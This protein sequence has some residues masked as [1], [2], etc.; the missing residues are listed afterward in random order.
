MAESIAH[1]KHDHVAAKLELSVRKPYCFCELYPSSG[2]ETELWCGNGWFI[3]G[4]AAILTTTSWL[5]PQGTPMPSLEDFC[6]VAVFSL[7]KFK[8]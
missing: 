6:T 8:H 5:L 7:S 1:P 3:G 4:S 2:L